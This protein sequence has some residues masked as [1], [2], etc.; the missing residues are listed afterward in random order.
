MQRAALSLGSHHC[1]A[2][3]ESEASAELDAKHTRLVD[4]LLLSVGDTR[5]GAACKSIES[6]FLQE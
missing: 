6:G 3:I 1:T 5:E 2:P 4:Q